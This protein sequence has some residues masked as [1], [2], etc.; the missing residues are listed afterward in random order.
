LIAHLMCIEVL[1]NVVKNGVHD[2]ITLL[3]Y[4]SHTI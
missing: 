3:S 1:T 4:V 2:L